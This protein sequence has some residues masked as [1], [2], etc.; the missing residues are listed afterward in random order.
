MSICIVAGLLLAGCSTTPQDKPAQATAPSEIARFA[1]GD[2][3]NVAFSGLPNGDPMM[4]QA[5]QEP[6]KEDGTISLPYIG[7]VVAAG[8]TAGELQTEIHDLYVP[9]YYFS[10][11]VTVS[12]GDRVYYVGGEIKGD[13]RQLYVDGT[14]VTKAIQSAGGLTDFANHHNLK[15]IRAAT[16]QVVTVDY[17]QALQNPAD[18]LPVYPNDQINVSKRLW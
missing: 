11:T 3:V 5:H 4:T 9:K 10:L 1:I 2:T 16:G 12:P 8:K 15:L 6:I 17:D 7:S 14:T 18:D 13:G